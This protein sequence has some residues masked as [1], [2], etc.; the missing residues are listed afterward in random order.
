MRH[1][2]VYFYGEDAFLIENLGSFVRGGLENGE[3]VIVVATA[4]HR[5][6]LKAKLFA[7]NIIGSKGH[8]KGRYGAFDATEMLSTF[9]VHGWPDEKIF[10]TAT[11]RMIR[12]AAQGRR[13]RIYGEMVAVLWAQGRYQ[14]AL[15]LEQLWNK[16]ADQW[17]FALLCGYPSS[18]FGSPETISV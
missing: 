8:M 16:L 6:R 15:R 2:Y 4:E 12:V 3:T 7:E 5:S 1:H 10:L 14:A 11:A 13:V 9:L 17:D 18:Y